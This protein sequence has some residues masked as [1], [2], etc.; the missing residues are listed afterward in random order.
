MSS[1]TQRTGGAATNA[2]FLDLFAGCGGLA[3]GFKEAGF[4]PIGAVELDPDAAA[5]YRVNVDRRIVVGDIAQ[6]SDWPPVDL[7]IGGPPCQGFSQLGSRDPAD[8]RNRLWRE[9][10][11]ALDASKAPIFVMENVPRLLSS[12]QFGMFRREVESRGFHVA[13]GVLCAAD[14]GVP[15]MRH[16]AI[17]IGSQLGVPSLPQRTHGPQSA[18][19][20]P[21]ATVRDAFSASPALGESADGLNW[22]VGRPSIR[23]SS[24]VRYS[25]VPKDGGNR[26]QMQANLDDQGQGHLVPRCW[27]RKSS[28]TTDVFGRLWWD[29]PALTVRTEFFKPEKGRYL[30]PSA[31]RPIT[32]REAARLQS[33][34]DHFRFPANQSMVS[35]ARQV[36]NAVP[37]GLAVAVARAVSEGI[38]RRSRSDASPGAWPAIRQLE[39]AV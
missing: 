9:Y 3:F 15:Q 12:D 18:G 32:V 13:A 29:R 7:V 38:P 1:R 30:H 24:L 34:P 19:G 21:W 39:L 37:P 26:F 25:A 6:V 17:V 23:Q 8:P 33:F 14:Y 31:N 10:L 20:L 27:R 22:H 5:T 4:V 11:R 16:R 36:G 28:G 2:T 35:V